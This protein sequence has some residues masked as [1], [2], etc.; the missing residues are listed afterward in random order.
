MGK[1]EANERDSMSD[2]KTYEI[3]DKLRTYVD[4]K[5]GCIHPEDND[6]FDTLIEISAAILTEMDELD[7][8]QD[9]LARRAVASGYDLDL[10][11]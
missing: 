6:T 2:E 1:T 10:D 5:I 8:G 9:W 4:M 3:L 7:V 11:Q